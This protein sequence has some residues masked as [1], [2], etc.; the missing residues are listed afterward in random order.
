MQSVI[1]PKTKKEIVL[2]LGRFGHLA[3]HSV[4]DH[5]VY[6]FAGQQERDGG[7][8]GTVRDF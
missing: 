4:Q 7:G 8:A 1:A 6:I 2:K 3:F 5:S